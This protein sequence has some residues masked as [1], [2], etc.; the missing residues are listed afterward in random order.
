M[1][2][3]LVFALF[4]GTNLFYINAAIASEAT[5]QEVSCGDKQI[6]L[7]DIINS[8]YNTVS[9]PIELVELERKNMIKNRDTGEVLPFGY[10]NAEW[11][12]LKSKWLPGD[13]FYLVTHQ[14]DHFSMSSYMLVRK[15]CVIG[16][17]LVSIS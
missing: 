16:S 14:K 7:A 10:A 11:K 4:V 9:A 1:N 2:K 15:G 12:I 17:L 6:V 5:Q 8:K 13:Q 3:I